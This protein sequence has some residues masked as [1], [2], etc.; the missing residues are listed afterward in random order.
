MVGFRLDGLTKKE[1]I[2]LRAEVSTTG[3]FES[4]RPMIGVIGHF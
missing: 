4:V 3:E 2:R 1:G